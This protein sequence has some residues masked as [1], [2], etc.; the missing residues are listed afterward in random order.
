MPSSARAID[1]SSNT[2]AALPAR[3]STAAA[4]DV[5]LASETEPLVTDTS[6]D[7]SPAYARMT[8]SVPRSVVT[9]FP[10]RTTNGRDGSCVTLNSASPVSATSRD[11]VDSE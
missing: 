4:V 3:S 5:A 8:N 6:T 1:P 7:E 9:A 10:A 11:V 2:P